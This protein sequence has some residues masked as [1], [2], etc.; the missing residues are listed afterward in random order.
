MKERLGSILI[1]EGLI[2]PDQRD[3][4]LEGQILSGGRLGTN[5]VDM[6]LLTV[7][8][9][10]QLL[11]MQHGLPVASYDDLYN[12]PLDV[13]KQVPKAHCARY[14]VFP[15]AIRGKVLHLAMLDPDDLVALD[16]LTFLLDLRIAPCV[17]PQLRLLQVLEKR[18]GFMRERRFLRIP[19]EGDGTP[20]PVRMVPRGGRIS[21]VV[22]TVK[23]PRKAVAPPIRTLLNTPV[24]KDAAKEEPLPSPATKVETP[25]RRA[26]KPA[27]GGAAARK[28]KIELP[29]AT[30]DSGGVTAVDEVPPGAVAEPEVEE[31]RTTIA[32][33]AAPP[34][35]KEASV[36][37]LVYLDAVTSK[38]V[39]APAPD[40]VTIE[41]KDDFEVVVEVPDEEQTQVDE[42]DELDD[43]DT[44]VVDMSEREQAGDEPATV[45][46][47]EPLSLTGIKE[48]AAALEK[49]EDRDAIIDLLVHPFRYQPVMG[50]L[51]L[52]R[53]EMAVGLSASHTA[54]T[55]EEV[56]G[57]VLPLAT[58]SLLREAYTRRE[59]V[60]GKV[61]E[62]PLQ[63]VI[64]R[65]LRWEEPEE[66]CVA[67]VRHGERVINLLC[68]QSTPGTR[69]PAG[70]VNEVT[71]LCKKAAESYVQLI[72][73]HKRPASD[74]YK[75]IVT[76]KKEK[77]DGELGRPRLPSKRFFLTGYVGEDEQVSVWRAIDTK[78]QKV[79][80]VN[81]L[82]PGALRADE[83]KRLQKVVK[84]LS[85][86][87][88]ERILLPLEAGT[89]EPGERPYLVTEYIE[90]TNLR[91][92]LKN[93][94]QPP[95]IEVAEIIRQ[96]AEAL[97][98]AHARNVTHGDVRPGNVRFPVRDKLSIK[99][100]G[101]GMP[102]G[103]PAGLPRPGAAHYVAP[104]GIG[105]P[106]HNAPAD[107]FGLAAMAW[108]MLG[109]KPVEGDSVLDAPEL[110]PLLPGVPTA[111]HNVIMRGLTHS[112][113]RR[114]SARELAEEL[115]S[116]I[117]GAKP[118]AD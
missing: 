92:R 102:R 89:C 113:L 6:K 66:V 112:P 8:Q 109:G 117:R 24:P 23:V 116:A 94:P 40:D 42:V 111:A 60:V 45:V 75:A 51:L 87:G 53:G 34:A 49:V 28:A 36:P 38:A 2:T 106:S 7:D 88:H 81:V 15:L 39:G 31:P 98:A 65:Y 74:R 63:L 33:Q 57:L 99:L 19:D 64:A 43:V 71:T 20:A 97:G 85:A 91:E 25:Q 61:K 4:A 114:P 72:H 50:V 14:K 56:R 79:V 30:Y 35:P 93:R 1:R 41:E 10:G 52:V 29:P 100:A 76:S 5:L 48:A 103:L 90:G 16:E 9:V 58:P 37:E 59:T 84:V 11:S 55:S 46:L 77:E 83:I 73:R 82:T 62:D 95:K 68:V 86:L 44:A 108:E 13:V 17:V 70:F 78:R 80:A 67:P 21:A 54:L 104:E 22:P 118:D 27:M 115:F 101:F 105:G 32:E 110:P 26:A 69:F 18:H 3:Q 12:T 107:V 96:V 47:F